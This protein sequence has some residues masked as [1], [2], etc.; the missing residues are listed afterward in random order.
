MSQQLF[1]PTE[2]APN[3][4]RLAGIT[5]VI[6][7][8]MN[9]AAKASPYSRDEIVDRMNKLAAMAGV[10]LTQGNVKKIKKDTLEKWLNPA[11]EVVPG[12]RAVEVFMQ[13]VGTTLPL[14]RWGEEHGLQLLDGEEQ[15]AYEYG[16]TK[17]AQ[18]ELSATERAILQQLGGRK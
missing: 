18:K 9:E 10:R 2:N 7:A 4:S 11:S 8:A 12:I 13:A 3:I 17:I 16:K 14:E 6:C 1:L 15:L 5:A